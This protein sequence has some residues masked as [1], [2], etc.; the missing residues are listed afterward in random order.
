MD[1]CVPKVS[2]LRTRFPT[3]DIQVDGGVGAGTVGCCARAGASLVPPRIV[4][5]TLCNRLEC[6]RRWDCA[7]WCE[8]TRGGDGDDERSG[9]LFEAGVGTSGSESLMSKFNSLKSPDSAS[10]RG[11]IG[12]SR[13]NGRE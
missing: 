10:A 13:L 5:L 2:E 12:W 11:A 6:D 9:G 1:S 4:F 7:V 8:R 3:K